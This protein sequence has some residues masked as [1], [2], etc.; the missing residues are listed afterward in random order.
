MIEKIT[1]NPIGSPT[2]VTFPNWKVKHTEGADSYVVLIGTL[3]DGFSAHGP[4]YN[5]ES[6]CSFADTYDEMAWIME[7]HNAEP[8]KKPSLA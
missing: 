4:F 5:Y 7:M 8:P 1:I 2:V 3:S 6:A